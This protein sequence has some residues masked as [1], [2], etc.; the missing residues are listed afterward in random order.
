MDTGLFQIWASRSRESFKRIGFPFNPGVFFAACG[1][2]AWQCRI[3]KCAETLQY[4]FISFTIDLNAS[5]PLMNWINRNK[6]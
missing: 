4:K 2:A 3:L 5:L 1:R 6:N